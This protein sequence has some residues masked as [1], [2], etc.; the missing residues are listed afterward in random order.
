MLGDLEDEAVAVIVGLERGQDR[1][2]LGIER[3][4]DDRADDLTD[5]A[6]IVCSGSG[7]GC[8]DFS[9][10]PSNSSLQSRTGSFCLL[11]PRGRRRR[12]IYLYPSTPCSS[13]PSVTGPAYTNTHD[14]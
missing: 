3:H 8:H 7:G 9:P 2:Q 10:L 1:R 11:R 4:V 14:T 13:T 12:D 6:D 5:A